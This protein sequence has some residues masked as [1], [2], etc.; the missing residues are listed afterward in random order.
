M[1]RAGSGSSDHLDDLDRGRTAHDRIVDEDDPLTIQIGP[2]R[3]VL[4]TDTEVADLI[5]RLD[6]GAA[7]VMVADDSKLEG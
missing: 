3:I 7:D 1:N 2:A 6:E 5:G 4:Q